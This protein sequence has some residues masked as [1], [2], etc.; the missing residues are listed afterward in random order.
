MN[1]KRKKKK[2]EKRKKKKE[3]IVVVVFN[4]IS[5][6]L[7]ISYAYRR[8]NRIHCTFIFTSLFSCY[9]RVDFLQKVLLNTNDFKQ[10]SLIHREEHNRNSNFW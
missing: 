9:S 5:T 2:N 10:I 4:G 7:V 3:T 8:G 6:H 1:C